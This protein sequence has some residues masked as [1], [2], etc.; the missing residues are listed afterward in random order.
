MAL[1]K[2]LKD[3]LTKTS[4]YPTTHSSAVYDDTVGRL[5]S[6]LPNTIGAEPIDDVEGEEAEIR[7][8]DTLGGRY[9]AED[10]DAMPKSSA[11]EDY[12]NIE[13]PVIDA[14]YLGGKKASEYA[15]KSSVDKNTADI[16]V[17]NTNLEDECKLNTT[18]VDSSWTGS[19]NKIIEKNGIVTISLGIKSK[20]ALNTYTTFATIPSQFAPKS[21]IVWTVM[22]HGD[23]FGLGGID[24]SGNIQMYTNGG[25][26]VVATELISFTITYNK[27]I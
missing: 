3:F 26:S 8:A 18:Y 7:D 15:T 13:P 16:G 14:D 24:T 10:L 19:T 1:I 6:Y 25:S 4:I 22:R 17:I 12:A 21:N 5:D 20:S 11:V 23:Y 27:N 2:T 9:N